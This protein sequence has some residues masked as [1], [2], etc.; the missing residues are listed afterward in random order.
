MQATVDATVGCAGWLLMACA[1]LA[2]VAIAGA[3]PGSSDSVPLAKGL[4]F[5][6]TSHAGLATT[7]GSAPVADTE[8]VYSVVSGDEERILFRFTVSAP[9]DSAAVKLLD[10]VPRS[11]DRTVRRED[12]RAASRLTIFW[13][14][15]DPA[16]MPGQT[17]ATTSSAV[18]QALHDAGKVAFI[19]G[20]NEP[21]EGLKG[22][23]NLAGGN[24][25]SGDR[26]SG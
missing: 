15:T 26:S 1:T 13:N 10:G 20:V 24:R 6:T 14:S 5:T 9:P 23:A 8:A 16:L 25:P 21:E 17:F 22:L 7:A 3:S 2:P 4:V 11:F 19:L 12:L 18:L